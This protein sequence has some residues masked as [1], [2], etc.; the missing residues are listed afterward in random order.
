MNAEN[1]EVVGRGFSDESA[2]PRD[3]DI[4][5]RCGICDSAIP[6]VPTDNIGCDC[7]NIFID[8]DY[9]RLIVVDLSK[10]EAVRLLK[11]IY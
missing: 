4:F 6:S 1:Y 3:D 2:V 10:L 5:Y 7:G 11:K 8:K 9:W